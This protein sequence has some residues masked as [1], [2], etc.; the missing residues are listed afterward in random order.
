MKFVFPL[1][2]TVIICKNNENNNEKSIQDL[3]YKY[4]HYKNPVL[5]V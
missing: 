1:L 3:G 4:F 2:L 5:F